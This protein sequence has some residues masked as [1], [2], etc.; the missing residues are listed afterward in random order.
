M[1]VLEERHEDEETL[2]DQERD[3]VHA[4]QPH[5]ALDHDGEVENVQCDEDP[6][7]EDKD[8]EALLVVEDRTIRVE[9]TGEPIVRSTVDVES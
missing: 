3:T 8:L 6:D 5:Q 4:D 1:G 7:V 9:V 2:D